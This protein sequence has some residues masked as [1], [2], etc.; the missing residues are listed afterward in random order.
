MEAFEAECEQE[1]IDAAGTGDQ[2]YKH[3]VLDTLGRI[4]NRSM[5]DGRRGCALEPYV[6]G[7]PTRR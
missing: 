2:F 3:C 5:S 4:R 6:Q 7:L 1:Q